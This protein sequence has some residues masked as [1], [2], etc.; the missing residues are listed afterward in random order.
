GG[1][2]AHSFGSLDLASV[3]DG[4]DDT[5]PQYVPELHAY[6]TGTVD[7]DHISG[8]NSHVTVLWQDHITFQDLQ[9]NDSLA[10]VVFVHQFEGKISGAPQTARFSANVSRVEP[11][12]NVISYAESQDFQGPG[13]FN[14]S[15]SL[16][17]PSTVLAY[18]NSDGSPSSV[19]YTLQLSASG[20]SV[21][22]SHSQFIGDGTSNFADT[23]ALDFIYFTD[24]A[25]NPI[26]DTQPI[27]GDNGQYFTRAIPEPTS[28]TLL[29]I[30]AAFLPRLRRAARYT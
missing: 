19:T 5:P 29:L 27:I 13:T 18:Q 3:D 25:G 11:G 17:M 8:G 30:A 10:Y 20:G 15:I 12:G 26:A 1:G 21:F 23:A 22:D 28:A 4:D 14:G 2:S 9:I 6:A 7:P 24:A 16:K